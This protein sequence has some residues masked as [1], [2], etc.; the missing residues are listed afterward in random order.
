MTGNI[1]LRR[2][3]ATVFLTASLGA[4]ALAQGVFTGPRGTTNPPSDVLKKVGIE[5]RL[6][7][8]IPLD[9]KFR[10]ESGREVKLADYFG[11]RPVVLSM[12]YYECPMLCGEVLN[13]E[14]SVFSALKFDIGKEYEVVTVSFDPTE[15]PDLARAKKRNFVERYGRPGGDAGWHFLTGDQASIDALTK[16]VGFN[17]AWDRDTKQF[18][19]A[20]AI[21]VVTPDGR[22]AQYFYGVDYSPKDLRFGLVQ[23]SQN[24]IGNVVDQVLLYCYHYDPRTGKYGPVI[25]RALQVGGGL[26]ILI[27]GGFLIIMFR[28]EPQK[29]RDARGHGGNA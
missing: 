7:Q 24:K 14:A 20:A 5:Q 1:N 12:V 4:S 15:T 19:H 21:M 23:A 18:A 27:L 28:L 3:A 10:D 13:G 22:L 26:T 9:L 17:Y 29:N 25:S 6:N 8:Q 16:A 11:K 2:I